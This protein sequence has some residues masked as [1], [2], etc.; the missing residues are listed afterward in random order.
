MT[1]VGLIGLAIM[2]VLHVFGATASPD[3]VAGIATAFGDFVTALLAFIG[4]VRRPDLT[5][6]LFRKPQ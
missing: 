2:F 4:Q 6:G 5:V 1:G 3:S